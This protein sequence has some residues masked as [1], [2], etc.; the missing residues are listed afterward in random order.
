[1]GLVY[2][3]NEGMIADYP[4]ETVTVTDALITPGKESVEVKCSSVSRAEVE[5]LLRTIDLLANSY[6]NEAIAV[7]VA[8][9]FPTI[10]TAM[11]WVKTESKQA[12]MG[13]KAMGGGL[14]AVWLRPEDVGGSILN[15]AGTAAKGLY[16][17]TSGGVYS[18]L[19]TFTEGTSANMIPE[20][21]MKEE[22]ACVHI[23]LIDT[24]AVPKCDRIKF[25]LAGTPT[26]AQS[27]SL[28]QTDGSSLP[29]TRFELPVVVGPEGKQRID[30]DPYISGDSKPELLTILI[31]KAEDL[32]F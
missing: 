31:A 1:M 32:T 20:Q 24:V 9:V 5:A 14:A 21:T 28:T 6:Q 19:H 4:D 18:W 29:F 7:A 25:T 15:P 2:R 10:L 17:G 30:I 8:E 3:E 26:P 11:R 13:I 16:G 27:L 23:G 12:Y 22:A